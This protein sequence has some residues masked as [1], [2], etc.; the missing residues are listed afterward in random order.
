MN[1]EISP[2][3]ARIIALFRQKAEEARNRPYSTSGNREDFFEEA[4]DI[5]ERGEHNPPG[6]S[7]P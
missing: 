5:I 2:E 1:I 7:R 3:A 6:S 4:I